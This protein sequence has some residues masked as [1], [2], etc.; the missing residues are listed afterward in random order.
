LENRTDNKETILEISN[1]DV[2]KGE[3]VA[4][5][6]A[7]AAGKSTL[8][9]AISG[10]IHPSGGTIK[11]AGKDITHASPYQTVDMGI[12]LVPEGRRVFPEMTVEENLII[13]SFNKKARKKKD[14]NLKRAFEMFP[15]LSERKNQQA[16]TLS[17]GEQQMLAIGRGLMA[18]PKLMLLDEM[19]LGLAPITVNVLYETLHQIRKE[20]ITILFVEQN[21]RRSLMEA[22]RAYLMEAGRV[23]LSGT[24]AELK[25]NADIQK[26]YFGI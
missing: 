11:C 12:A 15:I 21:V 18:E 17:G 6:G 13:G 7:N 2:K 20:G 3:V 8:L 5:I 26:A 1:L 14:R 16:R 19:S 9:D 25:E 4:L 23:V 10:T 24:A 22:D